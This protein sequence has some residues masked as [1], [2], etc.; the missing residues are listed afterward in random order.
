MSRPKSRAPRDLPWWIEAAVLAALLLS[1]PSHKSVGAQTFRAQTSSI[2]VDV[3]VRD[4][5]GRLVTD[6]TRDDFEIFEDGAPQQLTTFESITAPASKSPRV[7]SAGQG[8]ADAPTPPD[9]PAVVAL[10]FDR[11]SQE[12]RPLARDAAHLYIEQALRPG[13]RAAV[14]AI[15]L[16]LI[17]LQEY[18]G[19]PE[20]LRNAITRASTLHLTPRVDASFAAENTAAGSDGSRSDGWVDPESAQWGSQAQTAA[21][22]FDLFKPREREQQGHATVTALRAVARSLSGLAARKAIVLLTEGIQLPAN[23]RDHFY[24]AIDEANRANV[25]VYTLDAAGLRVR[26]MFE[27]TRRAIGPGT[28]EGTGRGGTGEDIMLRDAEAGLRVLARE[29]GGFLVNDTN[30]LR[31]GVR[32]LAEEMHTYYLLAYTSSN[33]RLDGRYRRIQAKVGRRD[34]E[35]RARRGYH[36]VPPIRRIVP[37]LPYEA[38][39]YATL[40]A[41]KMLNEFPVRLAWLSFPESKRPGLT[42]VLVEVETKHLTVEREARTELYTTDV[43]VLARFKNERDEIVRKVSQHY[44]LRGPIAQI[45]RAKQGSILF[46]KPAELPPGVYTLEAAVFDALGNRASARVATI[47]IPKADDSTLRVSSLMIV[48]R[49]ERLP[50]KERDPQNPLHYGDLLLY[51]NLGEPLKKG[52]DKELAFFATV[53]PRKSRERLDTTVEVL[54]SGQSLGV[55]PIELPVS[56]ASG[57]IQYVGRLPLDP[58]APGVYQLRLNVTAGDHRVSRSVAVRVE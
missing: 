16:N 57:R 32:R 40:D 34:L 15:D 29:T 11:L 23:I 53:Y 27:Q 33:T 45:D 56:D 25:T 24:A 14:F 46:F 9:D 1:A 21:R 5:R 2:L 30:D 41:P 8:L 37:L 54:H 19:A 43:T 4:S 47:E 3:I 58:L 13:D 51:P 42:P 10:V 36:A 39:A 31:P 49:A 17:P 12:A 6:L 44:T 28:G 18:T 20:A 35:V 50:E 52:A 55:V 38:A 26:S 7:G 22:I 48:R